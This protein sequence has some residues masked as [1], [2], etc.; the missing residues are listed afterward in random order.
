[1]TVYDGE[2]IGFFKPLLSDKSLRLCQ[3]IAPNTAE[4]KK[5]QYAALWSDNGKF[6]VQVGMEQDSV[7]RATEKNEL[8]YIFSLLRVIYLFFSK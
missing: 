5:I 7:K 4:G 8:S 2:Q 3:D 6:I 1:M